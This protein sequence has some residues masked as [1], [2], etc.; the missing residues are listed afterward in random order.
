MGG[1]QQVVEELGAKQRSQNLREVGDSARVLSK[2]EEGLRTS[3][4]CTNGISKGLSQKL[5][6]LYSGGRKTEAR[7][8]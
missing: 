2:R 4:T 6:R 1:H 8:N 7:R 5:E 3:E